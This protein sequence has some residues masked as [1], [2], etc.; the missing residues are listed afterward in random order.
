MTTLKKTVVTKTTTTT[1]TAADRKCVP[2]RLDLSVYVVIDVAVLPKTR[3]AA[4]VAADALAG[5]ATFLQLRAKTVSTKEFILLARQ[6]KQEADKYGVAF[7][8][9]DRIDVA[10]AIDADG[11]HIGQVCD[12][13]VLSF[14]RPLT[15]GHSTWQ[16]DMP[17]START[18]LGSGKLIGVTCTN[19]QEVNDA[20]AG[21]ADYLGTCAVFPTATKAYDPGFVPLGPIGLRSLLATAT[22]PIVAIGG[23][24][25]ANAAQLILQ[26]ENGGKRI[27]GCA[28]VSAV[29][30]A[31]DVRAAASELAAVVKPLTPESSSESPAKFL[32]TRSPRAQA[33]VDKVADALATV[34]KSKP[35]VHSIT[36]YVVMNDNAN[37]V[38]AIGA[39]PIMAHSVAEAA[40]IVSFCGALVLN[41]GTLSDHWIEAMHIAGGA[42]NK[43]GIPVIMDP[44][45]AGATVLRQRTCVDLVTKIHTNIVKGNAGEIS[46]L[47]SAVAGTSA[48]AQSRGVDSEGEM[49]N[50]AMVVRVLAAKISSAVAMSGPVDYVSDRF[51][52]EVVTVHNGNEWLGKITGTGCDTS[53]L[54]AAFAA[55][56][57]S[58]SKLPDD[59]D[60]IDP[61]LVSAVG[62]IVSMCIAAE[63]A[64]N[65]AIK[66]PMSFK[67]A[68]FDAIA[69]LTP[70]MIQRYARVDFA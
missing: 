30:C 69:N 63:Q 65:Q 25:V 38:L 31:D 55:V 52:K 29:I 53:A 42:A 45:G 57:A 12:L 9:N 4:Q 1:V 15:S 17:L 3:T 13:A 36:N 47:A 19:T 61:F 27:A 7:V 64:A 33:L 14:W 41:I 50:P 10:L 37:V 39:S 58:E 11:V 8:V 49:A 62:G 20:C 43:L 46:F 32:N 67:T 23:I 16:D 24:N 18:L 22:V 34:R 44:V 26:S 28:V 35:L 68:L 40:D 21:G 70:Q 60:A 2:R 5:G 6:V 56:L 54:V 59:T 48:D 51:G 66:G